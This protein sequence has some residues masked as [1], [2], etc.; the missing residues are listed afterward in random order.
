VNIIAMF[1]FLFTIL[2]KLADT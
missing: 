2:L 1:F